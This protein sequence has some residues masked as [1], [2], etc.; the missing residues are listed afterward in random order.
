MALKG[1]LWSTQYFL[2]QAQGRC[3][4]QGFCWVLGAEDETQRVGVP[5]GLVG[6]HKPQPTNAGRRE[7]VK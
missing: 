7:S 5:M 2:L 4:D 3:S 6:Q 1:G